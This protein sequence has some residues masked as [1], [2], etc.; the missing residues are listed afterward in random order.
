MKSEKTIA[1]VRSKIYE[2]LDYKPEPKNYS[3]KVSWIVQQ[4]IAATNGIHYVDRIGKLSEYPIYQL[5]VPKVAG[6]KLMLDIGSG[7]GR[8]LVAGHNAGYLPVG[9]DIRLEF[10]KTQRRVLSDLKKHGYSVVAD[11]ENLPFADGIFDLVWSFSVIQ[12]TH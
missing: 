7:W 10:C 4:Q 2:T 6:R 8:W 1:F 3:G 12:H 11:L 9:I 5:P